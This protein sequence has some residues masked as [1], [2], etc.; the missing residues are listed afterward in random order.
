[1]QCRVPDQDESSLC[2]SRALVRAANHVGGV[3]GVGRIIQLVC[4]TKTEHMPLR[5]LKGLNPVQRRAD[6]RSTS[7]RVQAA[8]FNAFIDAETLEDVEIEKL[9]RT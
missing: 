9:L 1:M 8:T 5:P 7:A 4:R 3:L 2:H 6:I